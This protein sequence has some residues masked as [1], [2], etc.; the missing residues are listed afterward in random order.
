MSSDTDP[1]KRTDCPSD[2]SAPSV[3]SSPGIPC[4]PCGPC[5]PSGPIGPCIGPTLFHESPSHT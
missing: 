5:G 4:M 1:C 2:P 3:P